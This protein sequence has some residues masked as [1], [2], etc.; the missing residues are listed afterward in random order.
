MWTKH[1]G[2]NQRWKIEYLDQVKKRGVGVGQFSKQYGIYVERP[3]YIISRLRGGRYLDIKN[4]RPVLMKKN[5]SITQQ[6]WFDMATRTIRSMSGR[7][8]ALNINVIGGRGRNRSLR[9]TNLDL[10]VA[11]GS[12]W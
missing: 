11:T 1:K 6:W 12:W 2:A 8:L 3:F 9:T 5:K 4:N 7:K 10:Q